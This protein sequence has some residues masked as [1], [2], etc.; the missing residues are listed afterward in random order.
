MVRPWEDE[1]PPEAITAS[2]AGT[3]RGNRVP[4]CWGERD[5]KKGLLSGSRVHC[6]RQLT[7][8]MGHQDTE[9]EILFTGSV[10]AAY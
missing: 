10:G 1:P 6:E 2:G 7:P 5:I 9:S 4:R 8:E 3:A